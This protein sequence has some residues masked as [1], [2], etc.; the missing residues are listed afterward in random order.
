[1]ADIERREVIYTDGG[2]RSSGSTAIVAV[3][4]LA[5]LILLFLVFGRGLFGGGASNTVK[6]DVDISAPATGGGTGG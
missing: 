2:G 6:A 1:M 3:A 4:A 5:I